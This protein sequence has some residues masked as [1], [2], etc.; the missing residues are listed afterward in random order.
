[1]KQMMT[2][3]GA[4]GY[5]HPISTKPCKTA[6]SVKKETVAN[7]FRK[8]NRWRVKSEQIRERDKYL[9]R[10]CLVDR[11]DTVQEYTY[12]CISVHHIVPLAEDLDRSLDS[13]NLITVCDFHHRL[14]ETGRI[15]REELRQLVETTP[16][17]RA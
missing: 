17:P 2:V 10:V 12:E 6:Y 7:T 11:Y 16:S 9:C 3:C 15:P 14:A 4:C 13:D 8:T 5:L 1:M